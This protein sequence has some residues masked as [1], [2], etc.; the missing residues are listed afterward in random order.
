[1][2][3]SPWSQET[4]PENDEENSDVMEQ[5]TSTGGRQSD[6][7]V[8]QMLVRTFLDEGRLA[9]LFRV[10]AFFPTF[11]EIY[12]TTYLNITK[13]SI[14]PLGRPW[15]CYLAIMVGIQTL[16]LAKLVLSGI[17]S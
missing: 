1:M 8:R 16:Q 14:G 7:Y 15:K 11:Y 10:M 4:D 2:S 12:R 5:A 17:C 6:E 13:G 3:F 9:N